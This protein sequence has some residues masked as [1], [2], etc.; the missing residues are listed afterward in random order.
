MA[1]NYQV[2]Q[3][4]CIASVAFEKGFFPDTIWNHPENK[5]LKN[6]RKDMN[7][8]LPG[9][10]VYIPDK[11]VKEIS[12]PTNQ[13]YKYK[14]KGVPANLILVLHY[15]GDPIIEES[16]T[17]DI[18]GKKSEGKTDK[19]GK[20]RIPI[21]PN[22]K[23][24]KLVVGEGERQIEYAL[25]LGVLDPLDNVLGFKQRLLNLGYKVGKLD[26]KVTVEFKE[27]I[28]CFEADN[29]LDQTGEMSGTNEQKLKEVF[30]R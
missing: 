22:A 16:Y 1:E 12:E 7:V 13:V 6:S 4:D 30:G 28:K 23:K 3:G 19:E 21:Y 11:R 25:D 2:K 8:L 5:D 27:A 17:L 26:E 10:V 14:L 9:D 24:G 18:D 15:G 29:H 20:V